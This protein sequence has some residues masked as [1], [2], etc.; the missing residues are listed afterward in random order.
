MNNLMKFEN[1]KV[2]VFE[3]GG[4]V[5]FNPYDVGN[6]LDIAH[7]SVRYHTSKMNEK[8]RVKIIQKNVDRLH[9]WML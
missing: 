2:E 7:D 6:C 3:Y 1:H 4:N 9:V 5:L 8:Q